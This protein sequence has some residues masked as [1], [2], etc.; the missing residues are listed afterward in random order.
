MSA[1]ISILLLCLL[2]LYSHAQHE[3]PHMSQT[4]NEN[5]KQ[6]TS[7][8]TP[9]GCSEMMVWEMSTAS[10]IPLA[11]E[12]MSTGM[13]MIHGNGFLVQNSSNGPRGRSGLSSPNMLMA[14]IGHS[15]G[16]HYFNTDFM[17]TLEKWTFPK[18]GYPLIVQIGEENADGQPYIDA[19][20]PHSSPIMGLTFSDTIRL[21]EG[22]DYVKIFFAPRGQ[23][24][25]GPIAFMH[26]PTGMINPDAPLGHHT[27]QD[28]AHI[29]STVVGAS[30]MLGRT[31]LEASGF[32]GA[33][34]KPT[35]VDLPL[36]TINSYGVRIGYQFSENLFAMI[37]GA[38]VDGTSDQHMAMG[39]SQRYSGSIYSK[40]EFGN[41]WQL[42]NS[43][44]YGQLNNHE[45]IPVLKSYGEEFLIHRKDISH[46]FWGRIEFVERTAM[47]LAVMTASNMNDP[48]MVTALTA[49]YTYKIAIA[50]RVEAGLGGSVTK[51][52]LP[53]EFKDSYGGDPLSGKLFLQITGMKMGE[54]GGNN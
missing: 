48:K 9:Q 27:A 44:I 19:Q 20:H 36:G 7:A 12:G 24:T 40:T 25:D 32:N 2:P 29:S 37:S 34:P 22:N 21:G 11:M 5:K 50:D 18:D 15:Y 35:K 16:N 14:D 46:Q 51:D 28:V 4:S 54:Y 31:L 13:W 41:T 1:K 43:L 3:M 47:Q 42:H 30:L 26:R 17:L 8:S 23:A 38:Q 49:G 33:E 10:C 53:S 45:D 39:K 52:I 6:M